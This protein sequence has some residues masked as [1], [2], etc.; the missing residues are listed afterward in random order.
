[1][2]HRLPLV[3]MVSLVRSGIISSLE[4]VNAHLDQIERKNPHLNAFT[5]L[6]ADQAR[7]SARR[8]DQGLKTGLLHG[9]PVTVKDSFDVA[10]F[11]TRLGS[12]F[13]PETPALEDAAVVSL[14]RRAGAILLGKTNTPEFLVSYESDNFITGRTNNPWDVERT[15][16]GSSGGEAAAIA[17]FCSPG[18]VGSDGGGSVR[19]P[20]HFCGIAGLKPT[21]GRISLYGHRPSEG[22]PGISVAGPMARSVDDVRLLFDVLAG[23]DDRDPLTAP[24]LPR[25]LKTD[26]VRIGVMEQFYDVP[27]Q[28]S[29]RKAVRDAANALGDLGFPV[30]EFR[31]E[32]ID[33]APNLWNF[34]FGELPARSMKERIAGRE[35]EAHWTYLE[36]LDRQLDRPPASAWQVVES[37]G[38]RDAMRRRLL[39]QMRRVPVIL[40]PVASIVA[41]HHR[42]RRFQTET[43]PIGLF[44]AMMTVTTFNLLGLPGLVVPFGMSEEGLPVGVQLVGRPWEEELLLEIGTRLESA[45]GPFRGPE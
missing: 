35:A 43:K 42:E 38:A 5:I 37:M 45:R 25:A 27:V 11:P 28:A 14:L 39:E 26:G 2:L 13:A 24:V 33:R 21:P 30:D 22:V 16:G 41:F 29:V 18:G 32:G 19:V 34:F 8:A 10:G 17:G 4:L 20:A 40:L 9:V 7:E 31:P 3:E 44:Q 6:M 36:G 12:Y 15:P 23:Y 1:M